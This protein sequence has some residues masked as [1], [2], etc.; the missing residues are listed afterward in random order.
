GRGRRGVAGIEHG[1]VD[2][3]LAPSLEQLGQSPFATRPLE[4]VGLRDRFPGEPASLLAQ[5]VPQP[6]EL[7][8]ASEERRPRRQPL[9]VRHYGMIGETARAVLRHGSTAPSEVT[10]A[11]STP[12]RQYSTDRLNDYMPRPHSSQAAPT[13]PSPAHRPRLN[14]VYAAI[15][16]PTRRAIVAALAGGELDV[17]RLPARFRSAFNGGSKPVEVG[18]RVFAAWLDPVSLAR[19][20]GTGEGADITALDPKVG[21]KFRIVMRHRGSSVEHWGEY[22]AI[23]RPSLLSFTWL[24]ANTDHRPTVVTVELE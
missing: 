6:G 4:H 5:L 15:A 13:R 9:F 11:Q 8:L 17:G 21:G 23:E 10:V 14:R 19:W 12:T 24:S 7:L 3:Q 1:V 20:M 2:D 18:E 16:D 22:L